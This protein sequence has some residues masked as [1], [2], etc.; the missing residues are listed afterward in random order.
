MAPV[1]MEF[2]L[3]QLFEKNASDLH[4]TTGAPP[5]LRID[6]E[7]H[8]LEMERLST[9][10]A[11]RL[12]YSLLTDEQKERFERDHELDLSFG[13]E[14]LG[15]VRMNVFMQ[16]GTVATV[17]RNI[18][19]EIKSFEDLQVPPVVKELVKIPKGLVLIT[20]VTGSGKS[21]TLATMIDWI[22]TSRKCHILTVED[23]IEFLHRHKESVVD[24]REV[25]MDTKAF[26]RALRSALRQRCDVVLVGEMRD[27]ETIGATLTLAETGHLVFATLHTPD[28]AQ[29]I[30]RII[31]VFP[32]YQ[33]AQ[34]RAQLS[35]TLKAVLSQQLLP[36]TPGP[37][38]I[39][40]VEV[41]L[42]TTAV[43]NMIRDEKIHQVTSVI[44]TSSEQGMQTM[45]QA[46]LELYR[47][48]L[49]TKAEILSRTTEV[50]DL[51]RLLK[52][53]GG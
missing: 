20:G 34:V 8:Q 52:M 7:V 28:A 29:S 21:T 3:R 42:C 6:G 45:N 36:R 15:R 47:K 32:H 40:A 37:G 24:Q 17:L 18:P 26:G 53:M 41:L 9:Q 50:K 12:I 38:R 43:A 4:I 1:T 30:N 27:L 13:V 11:Q 35:F 5:A 25:G 48:R 46:L 23:P 14:G 19:T 2:L 22:N 44:Q 10:M 51:E 33:Q 49:V 31:D 39:I 16:R